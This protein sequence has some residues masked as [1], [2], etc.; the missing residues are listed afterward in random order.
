MQ[1]VVVGEGTYQVRDRSD[2]LRLRQLLEDE[3]RRLPRLGMT[4]RE[5]EVRVHASWWRSGTIRRLMPDSTV[6]VQVDD[7]RYELPFNPCVGEFLFGDDAYAMRRR[8]L[9]ADQQRARGEIPRA[10]LPADGDAGAEA[11]LPSDAGEAR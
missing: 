7:H 5:A 9:A 1:N 8:V 2:R 6:V 10:Y 11:G 3:Y 4:R